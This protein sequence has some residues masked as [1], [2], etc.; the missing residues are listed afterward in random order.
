MIYP[1]VVHKIG[2]QYRPFVKYLDD[3]PVVEYTGRMGS[4]EVWGGDK[5]K[6]PGVVDTLS[7]LSAV[8]NVFY[9]PLSPS[10]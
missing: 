3:R 7:R 4:G 6:F 9:N 2:N 5:L 8:H 1:E 10:K